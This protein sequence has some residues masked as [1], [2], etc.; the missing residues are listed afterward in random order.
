[1][2]KSCDWNKMADTLRKYFQI[3]FFMRIIEFWLEF[4]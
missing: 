1:M 2:L 4:C 3:Q